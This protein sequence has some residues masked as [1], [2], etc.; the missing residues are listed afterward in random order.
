M[1]TAAAIGLIREASALADWFVFGGGDPLMRADLIDLLREAKR[2]GLLVEL[3]TNAHLFEEFSPVDLLGN[4]DRL[5][6]S[7]DADTAEAHDRFRSASD[8]FA[9][10]IKALSAVAPF[11][12][13]VTVRTIVS[14]SNALEIAGLGD[15]LKRYHCV[16]KWSLRQFVPL[17]RGSRRQDRYDISEVQFHETIA[18]IVG[19]YH[20]AP[21]VINVLSAQDLEQCFCLI[22]PDGSVYAH[23]EAGSNYAAVGQYPESTLAELV[24]R[25]PYDRR[26][27]LSV[28][29]QLKAGPQ[30]D[31]HDE[32]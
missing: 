8:N 10:N 2:C 9:R 29:P 22:A 30:M 25:V 32:V 7:L 23:P 16:K 20:D 4:I 13:P 15:V 24:S 26:G 17:G 11:R 5:G 6:L 18:T 31:E 27:R 19:R 21:F 12:V 14:A 1:P 3:Q 28:A